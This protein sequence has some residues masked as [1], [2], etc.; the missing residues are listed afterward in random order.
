MDGPAMSLAKFGG[1]R[2]SLCAETSDGFAPKI[3][4]KTRITR[5]PV[6]PR[7]KREDPAWPGSA[8]ADEII[9]KLNFPLS[10]FR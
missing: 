1:G 3:S 5:R 9:P 4:V 10:T 7:I 8:I 6:K 2:T